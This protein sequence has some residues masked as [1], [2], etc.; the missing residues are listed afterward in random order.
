LNWSVSGGNLAVSTPQMA[1]TTSG[2]LA[3]ATGVIGVDATAGNPTGFEVTTGTVHLNA[4]TV[5]FGTSGSGNGMASVKIDSST[6]LA[7]TGALVFNLADGGTFTSSGAVTGST[8]GIVGQVPASGS[9]AGI[10]LG[11]GGGTSTNGGF[12]GTLNISDAAG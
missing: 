9:P 4:S 10:I 5:T 2:T 11:G 7:S 6:G 1:A 3:A 8:I 12:T